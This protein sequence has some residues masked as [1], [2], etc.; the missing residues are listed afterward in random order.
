MSE[1]ATGSVVVKAPQNN[2]CFVADHVHA[3]DSHWTIFWWPLA[4]KY[5]T[6]PQSS[7]CP[8]LSN[9][10]FHCA[11]TAP[12]S[13]FCRAVGALRCSGMGLMVL[14]LTYLQVSQFLNLPTWAKTPLGPDRLLWG[15]IF[16]LQAGNLIQP[17][18]GN[19]TYFCPLHC[20]VSCLCSGFVTG[21]Y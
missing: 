9:C 13:Q 7:S 3:L 1:A 12:R 16:G 20:I 21:W 4:E 11:Q 8:Q 5:L 18:K 17:Q 2:L 19:V 14:Q 15:S 6:M 10:I